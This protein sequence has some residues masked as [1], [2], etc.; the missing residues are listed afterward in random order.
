M[1]IVQ[2]T[3]ALFTL[4]QCVS[5][6]DLEE[7]A[8]ARVENFWQGNIRFGFDLLQNLQ[9]TVPVIAAENSTTHIHE[10]QNTF[11]SPFSISSA[12]ALAYAGS[13]ASSTTSKQIAQ[14]LHYP[15][16]IPPLEF[17]QQTIQYQ[18]D[19][20]DSNDEVEIGNRVYVNQKYQ[21]ND[22]IVNLL[23]KD[24]FESMDC[25]Q[26][27]IATERI[28]AWI[29]KQTNNKIEKCLPGGAVTRRTFAMI[30]NVCSSLYV[31]SIRLLVCT[32]LDFLI[33]NVLKL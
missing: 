20:C 5:S 18:H 12:F 9:P 33:M 23:G 13:P 6:T 19:L 28:N 22:N 26:G 10:Y 15:T 3:L 31:S 2:I 11:F 4:W 17:A 25:D 24:S 32:L 29:A 8:H 27:E 14:T 30:V 7:A 1:S 21:L 16:N